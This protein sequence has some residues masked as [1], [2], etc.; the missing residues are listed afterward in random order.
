[1]IMLDNAS[2]NNTLMEEL[3]TELEKLGIPFDKDGNHIRSVPQYF[4]SV[5]CFLNYAEKDVFH[6]LSTLQSKQ[7]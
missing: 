6:M 2:N 4:Q 3:A 1:M 7:H 5:A